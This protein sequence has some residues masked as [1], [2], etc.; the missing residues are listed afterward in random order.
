MFRWKRNSM[1]CSK[2]R[3][4]NSIKEGEREGRDWNLRPIRSSN[5]EEDIEEISL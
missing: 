3:G 1:L 5:Q 4:P 2:N